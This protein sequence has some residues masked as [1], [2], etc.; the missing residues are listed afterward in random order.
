MS[1]LPFHLFGTDSR[2]S[3]RGD[4]T[5]LRIA[6]RTD[7][8]WGR[9]LFKAPSLPTPTQRADELR[10]SSDFRTKDWLKR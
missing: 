10:F 5:D 4:S 8:Q 3:N 6:S 2:V 1:N 9:P 7:V